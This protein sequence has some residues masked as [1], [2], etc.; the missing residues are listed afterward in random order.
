MTSSKYSQIYLEL[1]STTDFISCQLLLLGSNQDY[2]PPEGDVLPVRLRSKVWR[3][4]TKPSMVEPSLE[5]FTGPENPVIPNLS[6]PARES[7][8]EAAEFKDHGFESVAIVHSTFNLPPTL[9]A[10]RRGYPSMCGFRLKSLGLGAFDSARF[11]LRCPALRYFRSIAEG[12][13][14]F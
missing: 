4:E 8:T 3:A 9:R 7:S 5:Y 1:L 10:V 11:T 2:P 12:V 6:T 14:P 13:F